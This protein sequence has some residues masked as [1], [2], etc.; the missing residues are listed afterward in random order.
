MHGTLGLFE[1]AERPK[2]PFFFSIFFSM[3]SQHIT[4]TLDFTDDDLSSEDLHQT[5]AIMVCFSGTGAGSVLLEDLQNVVITAARAKGMTITTSDLSRHYR[6]EAPYKMYF[7]LPDKINRDLLHNYTTSKNNIYYHLMIPGTEYTKV[8]IHYVPPNINSTGL[9]KI[10]NTIAPQEKQGPFTPNINNRLDKHLLF[11]DADTTDIP[12]YISY[13]DKK[14][15]QKLQIH[16][17]IP[18]R[19]PLCANCHLQGHYA[20]NCQKINEQT[21]QQTTETRKRQKPES[22]SSSTNTTPDKPPA[23]TPK[24]TTNSTNNSSKDLR[25]N[26]KICDTPYIGSKTFLQTKILE[27]N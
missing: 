18:G 2:T 13:T 16:V 22:S 1:V 8:F 19:I 7:P 14:T 27:Q 20:S 12:H 6:L 5:R 3:S 10:C 15:Q 24:K 26:I 4:K 9:Q 11:V 23:T 17:T 21:N 25:T